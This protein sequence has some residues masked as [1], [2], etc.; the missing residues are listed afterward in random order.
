MNLLRGEYVNV[1]DKNV[2]EGWWKGTTER[3]QT[4]VFPSNFV[5]EVEEETIASPPPVRSR[6]S[7]AST[8]SQQSFSSTSASRVSTGISQRA[9]PLPDKSSRPTS[10]ATSSRPGSV[11]DQSISP[12]NEIPPPVPEIPQAPRTTS[13]VGERPPPLPETR[14]PPVPEPSTRPKSLHEKEPAE[15][16]P[17]AVS[18]ETTTKEAV[19]TKEESVQF[20]Q[21]RLDNES[22]AVSDGRGY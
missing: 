3:G 13:E 22:T 20:P 11:H 17:S 16:V 8:G 12:S 19:A 4:G 14:P 1:I 10:M 9:P 15:E 6:K 7:I 2:D 18:N 21:E 5:K